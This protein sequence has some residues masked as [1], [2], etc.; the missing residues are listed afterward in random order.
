MA[1]GAQEKVK[2]KGPAD[3]GKP[4]KAPKKGQKDGQKEGG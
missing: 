3:A 4:E 2:A 1:K